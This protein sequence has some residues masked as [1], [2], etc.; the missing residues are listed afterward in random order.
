[1]RLEYRKRYYYDITI[2]EPILSSIILLVKLKQYKIPHS[3]AI[4]KK[5]SIEIKKLRYSEH[6]QLY[7]KIGHH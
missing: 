4:N 2:L 3:N 5:S 1:M 7:I 6:F